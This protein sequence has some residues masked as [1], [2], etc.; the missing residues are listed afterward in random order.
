MAP[1]GNI[2]PGGAAPGIFEPVH[3]SAPD[4]AGSGIANPIACILSAAMLAGDNE[5]PRAARALTESVGKAL[6]ESD[7]LTPDLGGRASTDELA[8]AVAQQLAVTAG[9]TARDM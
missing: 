6:G 9:A 4:I 7:A 8:A 5:C 2:H 3:G 1:S